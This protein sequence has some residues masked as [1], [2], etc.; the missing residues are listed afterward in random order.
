MGDQLTV[1]TLKAVLKAELEPVKLAL[2]DLNKKFDEQAL[3]IVTLEKNSLEQDKVIKSLNSEVLLLRKRVGDLEQYSR[4]SNVI[5]KGVPFTKNESALDIVQKLAK[6]ARLN[7]F[8]AKDIDN[9]HW[10]TL[11]DRS[12]VI[13]VKFLSRMF[14]NEFVKA[15]KTLKPTT[16][17][18][19]YTLVDNVN[20]YVNEHLTGE[21][22]AVLRASKDFA[23]DNNFKFCWAK[24]CVVRLR[25]ADNSPV[26]TINSVVDLTKV[27]I[28]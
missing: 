27:P 22:L 26:F 15:V 7:S 6:K 17:S 11:R 28:S 5:I 3:K 12:K 13:I 24:D 19:G 16:H 9:L 23:R 2:S 18:L 10:L 1:D 8:T 21:T 20:I 25:K 14:K 4:R